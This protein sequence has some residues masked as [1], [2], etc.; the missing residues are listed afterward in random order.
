VNSFADVRLNKPI[1]DGLW[2][3]KARG[4]FGRARRKLLIGIVKSNQTSEASRTLSWKFEAGQ[5][6]EIVVN[7]YP[8]QDITLLENK[9]PLDRAYKSGKA[10]D[11]TPDPQP[12]RWYFEKQKNIPVS[13]PSNTSLEILK[14][15]IWIDLQR[16][17]MYLTLFPEPAYYSRVRKME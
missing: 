5:F 4:L 8:T 6:A 7:C 10:V 3:S 14:A 17:K 13:S 16:L 1:A 2:L 15:A 12:K 11:L 9:E